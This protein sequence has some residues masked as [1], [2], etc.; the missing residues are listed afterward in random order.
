MRALGSKSEDSHGRGRRHQSHMSVPGHACL[1][2]GLAILLGPRVGMSEWQGLGGGEGRPGVQ[3]GG[4]VANSGLEIPEEVRKA[5]L[6]PKPCPRPRAMG[7]KPQGRLLA[8]RVPFVSW[9]RL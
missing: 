8:V 5:P 6:A 1:T 3:V 9:D 4:A 2:Q 7:A